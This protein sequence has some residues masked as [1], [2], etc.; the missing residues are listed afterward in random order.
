MYTSRVQRKSII[1]KT[2]AGVEPYVEYLDSLRDRQAAAKIKIR[3]TR[4]EMGNLGNHR[5]VGLGVIEL[6]IDFGPG[7]RVY[8]APYGNEAIILL[9]AG[10]KSAQ[11]KDIAR[12]HSY[13]EDCRR[14][15]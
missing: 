10:D 11:D 4:A 14:N 8:V 3:V 5:T 7:Y 6:K 12:A 13:W 15:L 9:C 1:Y 2:A